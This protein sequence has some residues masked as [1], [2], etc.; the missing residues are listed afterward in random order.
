MKKTLINFFT[1]LILMFN[2]FT[3]A[4]YISANSSE[5][6]QVIK[7]ERF[8]KA[9]WKVHVTVNG[10]PGDFLLDTGGE[11]LCFLII[12]LKK[13]V[14]GSGDEQQVTICSVQE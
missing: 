10:K 4:N 1:V 14:V 3:P 6:P 8:R 12:F 13:L 7:L 5:Q 2:C 11:L 9:L